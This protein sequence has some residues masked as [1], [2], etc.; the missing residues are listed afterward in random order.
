MPEPITDDHI[1]G[2]ESFRLLNKM[3]D[4]TAEEIRELDAIVQESC[5]RIAALDPA[6]PHHVCELRTRTYEEKMGGAPTPAILDIASALENLASMQRRRAA[7]IESVR[8]LQVSK[9]RL[10]NDYD[11]TKGDDSFRRAVLTPAS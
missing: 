4:E 10:L 5:R 9:L 6:D 2:S 11:F 3:I 8:Q 1:L 7:A